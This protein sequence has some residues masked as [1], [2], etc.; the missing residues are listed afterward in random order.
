[1][2]SGTGPLSPADLARSLDALNAVLQNAQGQASQLAEKLLKA[3]VQQAIQ[4]NALGT[5][6]DTTA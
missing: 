6:I 1:M 4:D 2:V 3:G 5:L